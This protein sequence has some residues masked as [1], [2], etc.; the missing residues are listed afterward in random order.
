MHRGSIHLLKGFDRTPASSDFFIQNDPAL[1]QLFDPFFQGFNDCGVFRIDDPVNQTL[2]IPVQLAARLFQLVLALHLRVPEVVPKL[3]EHLLSND[4]QRLVRRELFQ[5]GLKFAFDQ[6][7]ADRLAFIS[8]FSVLANIVGIAFS[9]MACGPSR[10]KR[11][12]ALTGH[13]AAHDNIKIKVFTRRSVGA[14]LKPF[15]NP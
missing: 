13:N 9:S 8:A 3:F 5:Q 14:R 4:H 11:I 1:L 7:A 2:N 6:I 10:S 15:L 12:S